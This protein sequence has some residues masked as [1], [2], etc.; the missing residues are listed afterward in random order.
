M[1]MHVCMYTHSIC[2]WRIKKSARKWQ[3]KVPEEPRE[4]G[5][6]ITLPN[7]LDSVSTE[8][9]GISKYSGEAPQSQTKC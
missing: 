9:V 7:W 2:V 1:S 3:V 6:W 8:S 5:I 4:Q